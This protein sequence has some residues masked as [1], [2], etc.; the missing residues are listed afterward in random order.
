MVVALRTLGLEL[1]VPCVGIM[2]HGHG[3]S[4]TPRAVPGGTYKYLST[5]CSAPAPV[6]SQLLTLQQEQ[7]R[8]SHWELQ[9]ASQ[10][11]QVLPKPAG[12]HGGHCG[13]VGR[14]GGALRGALHAPLAD[15]TSIAQAAAAVRHFRESRM[16]C[17]SAGD[18]NGFTK[19]ILRTVSP[20]HVV[21]TTNAS[22]AQMRQ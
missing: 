22:P 20:R 3:D 4:H 21:G 15:T 19:H 1:P 9:R 11:L 8:Q 13:N 14:S 10:V 12:A 5:H 16:A 2:M 7:K 17:T 6:L 18:V